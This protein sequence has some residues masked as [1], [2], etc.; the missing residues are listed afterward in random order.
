MFSVL[1][2]RYWAPRKH[3]RRWTTGV[4]VLVVEMALLCLALLPVDIYMAGS[5]KDDELEH[6]RIDAIQALYNSKYTMSDV[7]A[8]LLPHVQRSYLV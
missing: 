8:L 1:G 3:T 7:S 2:V 6:G 5:S 4:A